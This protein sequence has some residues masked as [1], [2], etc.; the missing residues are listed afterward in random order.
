LGGI[1]FTYGVKLMT[2]PS[3][4][5]TVN[6][7]IVFLN[8]DYDDKSIEVSCEGGVFF[9]SLEQQ[10]KKFQKDGLTGVHVYMPLM[11]KIEMVKRKL[12]ARD[13]E[14]LQM[15]VFSFLTIMLFH[16][17][18][19]DNVQKLQKNTSFKFDVVVHPLSSGDI[20][21][22]LEPIEFAKAA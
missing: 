7:E 1:S 20:D 5:R 13:D 17:D 15:C 22:T 11:Q 6:F 18:C 10:H 9:S 19:A 21:M 16:E 12:I 2:K 4:E 3:K 14:E 8:E